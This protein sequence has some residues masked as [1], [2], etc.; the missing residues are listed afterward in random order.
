ML[1]PISITLYVT[2]PEFQ[3]CQ[4]YIETSEILQDRYNIAYHIVFRDGEY[5]PINLLRNV[6]LKNIV[7]PYVFAADID[8][9][10]MQ[11]LYQVLKNY[12][13]TLDMR[14]KALVV[15]A[16]E[17]QKYKS[18]VPRTKKELV[19]MW[20]NRE[21]FTFRYD[22]WASGHAPTNYKKWKTAKVPY[23]VNSIKL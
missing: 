1:G 3:A 5:Y 20:D 21:V 12:L 13:A 7:T 19:E 9:L 6:G 14:K 11:G 2:D 17:T 4:R 18:K 16:F 8:F 23:T 22:V 10:P 15:P